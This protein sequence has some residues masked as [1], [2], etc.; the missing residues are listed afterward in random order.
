MLSSQKVL[1]LIKIIIIIVIALTISI[2][3]Q[4][5]EESNANIGNAANDEGEI[6]EIEG[7]FVVAQGR[8]VAGTTM[9]MPFIIFNGSSDAEWTKTFSMSFQ[10]GITI[11]SIGDI[12]AE[13]GTLVYQ[14]NYSWLCDHPSYGCIHSH[15]TV[16]FYIKMSFSSGLSGPLTIGYSMTG[17]LWGEEPHE[18]SGD[19]ILLENHAP[20]ITNCLDSF[21]IDHCDTFYNVF[22]FTD[23]DVDDTCA[24]SIVSGPGYINS[25]TGL[26][27]Y[28]LSET[29]TTEIEIEIIDNWLAADTCEFQIMFVNYIPE[30]IPQNDTTITVCDTLNIQ[31]LASDSSA[32]DVLSYEILDGPGTI[33]TAGLYAYI[34]DSVFTDSVIIR[35]TDLLGEYTDCGFEFEVFNSNPTITCPSDTTVPLGDILEIQIVVSDEDSCDELSLEKVSGPGGI[36]IDNWYSFYTIEIGSYAVELKL[37]DPWGAEDTCT[38]NVM[39]APPITFESAEYDGMGHADSVGIFI[40]GIP[41]SNIFYSS[42]KAGVYEPD[43][44]IYTLG[45][46]RISGTYDSGKD[47]WHAEFG[48]IGNL[49]VGDNNLEI[50]AY[51]GSG[52]CGTD[53]VVV[54][55]REIP[56]WYSGSWLTLINHNKEAEFVSDDIP[57]YQ[58]EVTIPEPP[59]EWGP[60]DFSIEPFFS[61][62][63]NRI[64]VYLGIS[65]RFSIDGQSSDFVCGGTLIAELLDVEIDSS[66]TI[67]QEDFIFGDPYNDLA[68]INVY[69]DIY[70]IPETTLWDHEGVLL[71]FS[72]GLFSVD[73]LYSLAFGLKAEVSF[74]AVMSVDTMNNSY[75]YSTPGVE[76]KISLDVWA[77]FFWGAAEAGVNFTP[78]FGVEF[79]CSLFVYPEFNVTVDH[80][81][82]F[83]LYYSLWASIG[84][85]LWEGNLYEDYAFEFD[86][87]ESCHW[88]KDGTQTLEMLKN[89]MSSTRQNMSQAFETPDLAV[90]PN[91]DRTMIVWIQD[92]YPEDS[93]LVNPEV[94]YA[95]NDDVDWIV[96]SI[97]SNDRWE[98]NPVVAF[99]SSDSV[100]AV[101]TQNEIPEGNWTGVSDINTVLLNQDLYYSIYTFSSSSWST[102]VNITNNSIPDGCSDLAASDG[103]AILSWVRD[104]DGDVETKNDWNVYYSW[105]SNDTWTTPVS[106][107]DGS[108]SDLQPAAAINEGTD[109]AVIVWI[110]DADNDFNT[111]QDRS[112]YYRYIDFNTGPEPFNDN[113]LH[114]MGP[115]N[116]SV[117]F[118]STGYPV[119]AY[120]NR[121]VVW[122]SINTE[123][124][125]VGVGLEDRLWISYYQNGNWNSLPVEIDNDEIIATNPIVRTSGNEYVTIVF[126]GFVG[127][128]IPDFDGEIYSIST[129]LAAKGSWEN[130]IQHSSDSSITWMPAF[131]I[132]SDAKLVYVSYDEESPADPLGHLEIKTDVLPYVCGDANSDQSVNISDAVFI[133]NY[134]F[135]GGQAPNPLAAA[136]ANCDSSVNVSDA[137]YIINYTFSGGSAPCDPNGDEIPDC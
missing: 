128:N 117:D 77:S 115:L 130:L 32:C 27:I 135:A 9:D 131:D 85:G 72:A 103:K 60:Y 70:K 7:S 132:G 120:T 80:C 16:E 21:L 87:P 8:Y 5:I 66:I 67:P 89:L 64:Q 20:N 78:T 54:K 36:F 105:F 69:D 59:V 114:E 100:M 82:Y 55:V 22:E 104:L 58:M 1:R 119:I 50:K 127:D 88:S 26:F 63:T 96:G 44:V 113:I 74:G 4:S 49:P 134:A 24:W 57:Y 116:P 136:D 37:N 42:V 10:S 51:D 92:T 124:D 31:I 79:P 53:N 108:G 48:N 18:V 29:D 102:P 12:P 86:H 121:G 2:D 91:T 43:S 41:A 15:D 65:G 45:G 13:S 126:R 46:S 106:I 99:L 84:W 98:T 28:T 111:P 137:V 25:E 97:T 47:K 118:R 110:S 38:F 76:P 14:G 81:T 133:I 93:L 125:T 19:S 40:S 107:Y 95:Y 11:D 68:G 6:R 23:E 73:I 39:V 129:D 112:L 75:L 35:V 101:W 17:D 3:S 123:W 122:D 109:L 71:T 83:I 30:I 94:Y 34:P 52:A 56:S 62:L 61:D 90:D 33:D